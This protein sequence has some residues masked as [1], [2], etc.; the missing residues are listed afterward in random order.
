MSSSQRPLPTQQTQNTNIHALSGIWTRGPRNRAAADLRL[1]PH[2]HWGRSSCWILRYWKD[3]SRLNGKQKQRTTAATK[4]FRQTAWVA[5]WRNPRRRCETATGRS[6]NINTYAM[7][8]T[9]HVCGLHF[10]KRRNVRAKHFQ[11]R[12]RYGPVYST[13]LHILYRLTK[14]TF[15]SNTLPLPKE[16]FFMEIPRLRLFVLLI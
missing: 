10:P 12:R 9:L 3:G 16:N 11:T 7:T 1:G 14:C 15:L 8:Q 4:R 13:R 6:L 2:G 5:A